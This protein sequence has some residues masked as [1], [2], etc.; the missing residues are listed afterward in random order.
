[1]KNLFL[2]IRA[3]CSSE[4]M[5]FQ[6][7]NNIAVLLTIKGSRSA[8]PPSTLGL[9][10]LLLDTIQIFFV[11]V[12]PLQMKLVNILLSCLIKEIGQTYTWKEYTSMRIT[13]ELTS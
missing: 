1:M 10:I 12:S 6:Q 13:T 11:E 4:V 3:H 2:H 8:N 9:Q 5:S 7:R